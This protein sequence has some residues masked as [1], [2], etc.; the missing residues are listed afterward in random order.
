MSSNWKAP[1]KLKEPYASWKAELEIWQNFTEI[2][3]KKQGAALFLSLPNPSSARDAVLEL[4]PAAI[5]QDT[6]V[7]S[8][9]DK[10]D[11]LFLKDDNVLT[12]Q[13]W[14][15]FVKFKRSP[16]TN[17][18]DYTIEFNRL[19]NA[20]KVKKLALPGV[21]AIQY[22][23]SA[24][25]GEAQ[26]R[27]ALATCGSM[28]YDT[29]KSQVLKITTDL[30]VPSVSQVLAPDEIKVENPTLHAEFFDE[31]HEH[32]YQGECSEGH[33]DEHS[34]TLFGYR[35][36][37]RNNPN[38]RPWG[39]NYP[40]G[41]PRTFRGAN[42]SNY[43]PWRNQAASSDSWKPKPQGRDSEQKGGGVRHKQ[44]NPADRF[45]RA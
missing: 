11:S 18:T 24:N 7:K 9:I 23:E 10:L 36:W 19:Y 27:L 22:L 45:G 16:N 14:K 31:D 30:A 8:I 42:S 28:D 39:R 15:A 38:R 35:S 6:G 41:S 40:R 12:Y 13:A 44:I 2:E 32:E 29:M 20:C 1:P 43:A 17:M 33:Q 4:G 25:L 21:R 5:N 26:H 34:D 37:N 3:P